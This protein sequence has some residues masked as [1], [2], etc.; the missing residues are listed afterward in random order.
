MKT[1][2]IAI[3]C[4]SFVCQCL[5][6]Q[7]WQQSLN[8]RNVWSLAFNGQGRLYAGGLTGNN[9]RIWRSS[10]GGVSWDTIYSGTGQ[11][12]WDF[13]FS[14]NNLIY[15]A[16]FSNGLLKSTDNGITF[17][18]MPISMFNNKNLQGVECGSGEFVYV[19]TSQGFFRSSNAGQSFEETALTGLN[20]LPV[21]VDKDSSNIVYVGVSS[22]GGSGIGFYRSTDNGLTFSSNLNPGKNGYGLAQDDLNDVVYMITTTSPYNFDVST[23]NGLSWTTTGNIPSAQRGITPSLLGNFVY[24]AGNGGVFR[25]ENGGANFVNMNFTA[26][27]TPIIAFN[28]NNVLRVATGTSGS[29]GGVWFFDEGIIQGVYANHVTTDLFELHQNYPNPFNPK[30]VILYRIP[31]EGLVTLKVFDVLGNEVA[32]LLNTNQMAGSYEAEFD[33]SGLSSGIYFYRLVAKSNNSRKSEYFSD[34]K[35]MILIK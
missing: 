11:T 19:T 32:E 5:N 7:T 6:A 23:N 30:T 35:R 4:A 29:S 17:S 28:L 13:A 21:M 27:A 12:M 8:G 25:S 1:F 16:N 18:V 33:G 3:I 2:S 31:V 14:G 34:A 9:S 26:S 24:T 20:C 15:V 22:A 10:D